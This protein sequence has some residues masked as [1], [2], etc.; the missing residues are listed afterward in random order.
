M[1]KKQNCVV[2]RQTVYIVYIKA[3]D[4]SKEIVEDVE[5]KFDTLDYE[6]DRALPKGKNKK[7]I[8]LMKDELS[9][10]IM[11]KFVGL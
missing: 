9:G 7:V 2:W 3:D 11:T 1:T 10:K 6:L 8:E 4:I 5:T